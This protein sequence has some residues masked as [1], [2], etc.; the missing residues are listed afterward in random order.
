M[1]DQT[2]P[3][4]DW[5]P[6]SPQVQEDQ[7]A[8]YDEMRARCPVAYSAYRNWTVFHHADI[9]AILD[10]PATFSNA[11]SSHPSVPNGMDPPEHTSFRAI[12]DRYFTPDRM[13]AFEPACREVARD[14]IDALGPGEAEIMSGLAEPFANRIQCRFMGW[15]E[16]LHEPLREWTRKN[17]EATRALDREAMSAIALEFDG[18][19]REQLDE[20]RH[21]PATGTPDVTAEL[22]GE[23]VDGRPLTDAE[24]VSM[25]RNWTVGEL[26]TIAACVGILVAF[27]ASNPDIQKHLRAEPDRIGAACDEILRMRAP[28]IANRRRT[29]REVTVADRRIPAGERIMVLWASANRDEAVFG[30]PD[31]FR[32][33]RDPDAN[34]LYG[35]GIHNC[36][37]APLARLEL[38]AL[39]DELLAAT[40]NITATGAVPEHAAYPAGGFTRVPV[41]LTRH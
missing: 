7:I 19:I 15:P 24:L 12:N 26:S 36:P 8:A 2:E 23:R 37:G 11:V 10:D 17:R 5:D 41:V 25:I 38:T 9:V 22:L 21:R 16:R 27:L 18:Y 39:V 20:R 33:D 40:T 34:L 28:L 6:R 32:L 4:V 29:T 14:L 31:E 3:H 30:D 13:R 35:R 1:S